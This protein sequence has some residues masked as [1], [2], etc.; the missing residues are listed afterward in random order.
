MCMLEGLWTVDLFYLLSLR[1][2]RDREASSNRCT[3]RPG[4]V[5]SEEVAGDEVLSGF[6]R[7]FFFK[8][9]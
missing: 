4:F 2:I 8:D 3:Y 9:I 7:K 1:E 6:P 5:C